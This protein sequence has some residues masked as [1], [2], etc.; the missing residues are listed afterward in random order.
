MARNC[1][2]FPTLE[3]P[4]HTLIV[5][6]RR[7]LREAG[8]PVRH[9]KVNGGAASFVFASSDSFPYS[10][11]DLI[12]SLD[13]LTDQD[14]E[15]VRESVFSA[16][17]EMKPST[18]IKQ[19]ITTDTLRDVY[20]RKMVKV[21]DGHDQWSLFS[22]RDYYGR[23]I[24]LKF[25]ERMRRQFEFLLDS[26]Q[27]TLDPLIDRPT[28]AR[29]V[30][31]AESMYGDFLQ[32]L[33]HLNKRLIDTRNP[34]EIRGVTD[35]HDQWSLFSLRDYYGRVI[36]LGQGRTA[37]M[38]MEAINSGLLGEVRHIALERG[39]FSPD[40]KIVLGWAE[41]G[42]HQK[43]LIGILQVQTV[44]ALDQ[45]VR[46]T[47]LLSDA[48]GL[49][50]SALADVLMA[51]CGLSDGGNEVSLIRA[52]AKTD[53]Q[54]SLEEAVNLGILDARSLNVRDTNSGR[55]LSLD[56][57]LQK[58]VLDRHGHLEHRGRR[59]TLREA[60]DERVAHVEA[61]PPA[62]IGGSKKI[63][64]FSSA[65]GPV[66]AFRPVGQPVVEEHEQAWSFDSAQGLFVDMTT[67]ERIPL[68]SAVRSGLLSSD[69]LRVRDALTG[70]EM[71]LDEA[72]KWGIV[73]M[74]EAYYLDKT[75]NKR[76]SL[77][78]AA[79]QHRIYPTGGVP[80]NAADSLHTTVR[81]HTRQEM[82]LAEAM[83]QGLIDARTQRFRQGN[84]EM[85]LDD[86]LHR[87]LIDPQSEWIV[88]SRASGIGPTIEERTQETVTETGQQL[89]P[90]IFRDKE[91][92]ESV[93]TVKRVRRTEGEWSLSAPS[94]PSSPILKFLVRSGIGAAVL[95]FASVRALVK[96]KLQNFPTLKI[97]LHTANIKMWCKSSGDGLSIGHVLLDI[98]ANSTVA[99]PSPT[100]LS[101][102]VVEQH[103]PNSIMAPSSSSAMSAVV[104]EQQLVT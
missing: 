82:T 85:S 46:Q 87:G 80:E 1:E 47:L 26:F 31:R 12:F 73:N 28:D 78:E 71:S 34:E 103:A 64:Q 33:Y 27:I 44:R 55:M 86:A 57:A 24:E 13:L 81:V 51:P 17:L 60:I 100:E 16:L 54:L 75:D 43:R 5:N 74:R 58:K 30:V 68:E 48:H 97:Q 25:V 39:L 2:N 94:D 19:L 63:I 90:K 69:D 20:I 83:R 23:C 22:L 52:V 10:D 4:L 50:D 56:E 37:F 88:P 66:T 59:L 40:G 49:V 3:I 79:R 6:V 38:L 70:R 61:E 104:V 98:V 45:V 15:R 7:K 11:I 84:Q 65:A 29:P 67:N 72:Q 93:N 42:A 101:A 62:T 18:T 99:P 92:Q 32:A 53:K 89:A 95:F 14:S 9:V 77:A 8:L 41:D 36:V 35:G 91:L 96:R 21:T 76:Y 102:V